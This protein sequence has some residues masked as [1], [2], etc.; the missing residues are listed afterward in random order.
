[1]DQFSKNIVAVKDYTVNWADW[2]R[3]D[4][5]IDSSFAFSDPPGLTLQDSGFTPTT[6]TVW[7]ADGIVGNS[8]V[9]TNT[10]TTR[11]GRTEVWSFVVSIVAGPS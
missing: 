1:M 9:V 2:L 8:Y 7:I 5:I 6:A 11:L 10:V 4:T 3:G